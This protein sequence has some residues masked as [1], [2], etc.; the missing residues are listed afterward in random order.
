MRKLTYMAALILGMSNIANATEPKHVYLC[1]SPLLAFDFWNALQDVA[2][3]GIRL[4]PQIAEQIC[5][6]MRA[7]TEP[8]CLRI[9]ANDLKPIASGWGGA[10]ALSDGKTKV[11]FH[12]PDSP[13]WVHP[14][15][16]IHFVNS[17]APSSN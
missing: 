2:K 11:W 6:G 1:R 9:E 3:K 7:G 5:A 17:L 8:Q 4:T 15:M 13:G 16:Y 10:L 12:N 14:D